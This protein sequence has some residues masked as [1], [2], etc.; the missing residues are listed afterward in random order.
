MSRKGRRKRRRAQ[1]RPGAV[2]GSLA[3]VEG[4]HATSL[5]C[6]GYGPDD[7]EEWAPQGIEELGAALA[8]WP[9][10]WV[11]VAGLDDLGT[12]EK[13]GTLFG[14]HPLALEDV[15]HLHQR[16][17]A[18][19][20][21]EVVHVVTHRVTAGGGAETEQLSFFLGP[22]WVLTVRERSGDDF[23]PIRERL[24]RKW[25]RVR[26]EGA[27]YLLYA[28]LDAVVDHFF[29]ALEELDARIDAI[30]DSLLAAHDTEDL[31][32]PL[33]VRAELQRLRRVVLPMRD[34]VVALGR[35]AAPSMGE[36]TRVH[37]RDLHD[38]LVL[39]FDLIDAARERVVTALEIRVAL[40][41]QRLNEVMKVL[42]IISTL[43]IPLGFV[44]G[45]Y[46]MNFDPAASRWNM[47]ELRSPWGYPAVLVVMSLIA[48]G[49]LG[50]MWRRG[51]IGRGR[52]PRRRAGPAADR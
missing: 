37:L 35:D 32:T 23:E 38:H 9:V 10:L 14:I 13:L 46:G 39:L 28:L 1:V 51:W 11:D 2:P 4:A 24:R 8:R 52:R 20:F 47:P 26:N 16:P 19:V 44:A 6:F 43:F 29:P 21:E 50:W 18:Q 41:G 30:E 25:G 17:K 22:G 7:L 3:P 45:L 40:N 15:V 36:E 31:D 5:R 49:L 34:A 27:D 48:A 12:I 33:L 42:T